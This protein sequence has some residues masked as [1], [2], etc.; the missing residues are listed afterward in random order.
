MIFYAYIISAIALSL[1]FG[2]YELAKFI[3]RALRFNDT[4]VLPDPHPS[5]QREQWREFA[6]AMRR[7]D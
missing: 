7:N 2:I 3:G 4:E 6:D 1:G 5:T